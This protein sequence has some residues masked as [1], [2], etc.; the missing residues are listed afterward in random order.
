MMPDNSFSGNF[1][2]L[3]GQEN[4]FMSV[5]ISI[6][7]TIWH[8]KNENRSTDKVFKARINF[9]KEFCISKGVNA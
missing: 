3:G 7:I 9:E 8:A 5:S 4:I 2:L 1:G 6:S